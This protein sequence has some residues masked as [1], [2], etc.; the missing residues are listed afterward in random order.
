MACAGAAA[1]LLQNVTFQPV[2]SNH[3]LEM[4]LPPK[5]LGLAM[6]LNWLYLNV[7]AAVIVDDVAFIDLEPLFLFRV[8]AKLS[9]DAPEPP[10]PPTQLSQSLRC[11]I[12]FFSSPFSLRS[13][14]VGAE[15]WA[16]GG[17]GVRLVWGGGGGDLISFLNAL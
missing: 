7:T 12:Y 3:I 8:F 2:A 10:R 6:A 13:G 14:E 9:P 11:L 16:G 15:G 17:V 1:L 5:A 4:R